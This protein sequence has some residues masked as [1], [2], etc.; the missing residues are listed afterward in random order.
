MAEQTVRAPD[1]HHGDNAR[2]HYSERIAEV[3]LDGDGQNHVAYP[4]WA[5]VIIITPNR[6]AETGRL[7]CR[8]GGKQAA[9]RR[10]L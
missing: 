6:P 4:P 10:N 3:D 5:E 2:Q 7:R 9:T 8:H 1:S